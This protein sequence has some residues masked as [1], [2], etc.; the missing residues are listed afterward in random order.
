[1]ST[2]QNGAR[3]YFIRDSG[4]F[5]CYVSGCRMTGEVASRGEGGTNEDDEYFDELPNTGC[6]YNGAE[7][8]SSFR[9]I[10]EDLS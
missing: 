4:R 2:T 6:E 1:M 9:Q 10:S 8:A 7:L 5:T 3:T